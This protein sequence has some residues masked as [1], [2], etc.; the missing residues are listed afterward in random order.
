M[1]RMYYKEVLHSFH[2]GAVVSGTDMDGNFASESV[3][4]QVP[5]VDD[6]GNVKSAQVHCR[7]CW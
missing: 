2:P 4:Q 6:A 7:S 3:L 1:P 5:Y